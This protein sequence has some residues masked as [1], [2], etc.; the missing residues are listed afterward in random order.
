MIEAAI[1]L[2]LSA[3]VHRIDVADLLEKPSPATQGGPRDNGAV[4]VTPGKRQKPKWVSSAAGRAREGP[5]DRKCHFSPRTG[6][7]STAFLLERAS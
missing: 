5:P 2:A 1:T 6:V 4:R 3:Y 7:K